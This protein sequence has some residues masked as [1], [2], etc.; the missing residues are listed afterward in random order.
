VGQYFYCNVSGINAARPGYQTI[1]IQPV[2][3]IGL[4]WAN[5]SYDSTR[6]LISTAWT[7][8]GSTFELAVAI[9]PNTTAQVWVPTTA[10]SVNAITESGVPA[11][12]SPGVTYV[13]TS[14]SYAI[15]A[16]GSGNYLWSSP[17]SIAVPP[18]VI[19]TTTNQTGTSTNSAYTPPWNVVTNGSLI[20]GQPPT[21]AV[22][23]FSEE[24]SG[25]NVNSLTAG[26][27]L[28]LSQIPGNVGYTT[29]TNYVTCG[30]GSGAGSL[31][32]YT[33]PNSATGYNLTNI[34]VYGGWDDNG[35]DQQAYTVY[36]STVAAPTN[37]T[38]LAIVNFNPSIPN[39]TPSAT[40][41]TLTS[42]SGLLA[43]NVAA[44]KFDFSSPA[45]EN[46]YCGY[47]AITVFGSVVPPPPASL[48]AT[49][50][51]PNGFVINV[52]NLVAGRSYTLQSTTNLASS[53]WFTETN[54]IAAAMIAAITNSTTGYAEKFYRLVGY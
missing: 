19:I 28:S 8:T 29:S 41:V 25:R 52:G 5:A 46:G 37:F 12:S 47:A 31:L 45:S 39:T 1:L 16:V 32:I 9:P 17:F 10:T 7:N 42:S 2:P 24:A 50:S 11:A 26:G 33:L 14:N 40:R 36:Y 30:N 21:T 27:S 35:R 22:G 18:S 4:T 49:V 15:F 54:F 44:L 3:G 34:T 48:N 23:N 20:A 13:G 51:A 53:I 43:T 38:Q 6:G